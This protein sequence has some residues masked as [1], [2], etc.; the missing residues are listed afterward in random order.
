MKKLQ[1]IV[2]P[3]ITPLTRE[4]KLDVA[5][6]ERLMER[7]IAG[8]VHGFFILGT[9]GEGPALGAE[10]QRRMITES[11]RINAGRLPLL[12]GISA[13]SVEDSIALG[14]YS[15][16][17]GAYAVVA[18]PPSYFKP[19]E[20][21]LVDFYRMLAAKLPLPL[22]SYNMP[23]M[24]G[25]NL[26]PDLVVTL[27]E[28]P[29][30]IGH[31]DSSGNMGSFHYLL[32]RLGGRDDFAI[33]MGPEEL[34]GEAVFFGADGGVNGGANLNPALYVAMYEA[35]KRKDAGAMLSLQSAI[36]RQM[37]LYNCGHHQSSLIKGLK[38][39]L[40]LKGICADG[41]AAPFLPFNQPERDRVAEI[42]AE[43]DH[44]PN[45]AKM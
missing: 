9:T 44:F 16:A 19:G 27:A 43:L 26:S 15:H 1:G 25:I 33:F 5:G 22:F 2:P 23:G 18:T 6:L 20:A 40:S 10:L 31:K 37:R 13:T 3:V 24:T 42:L 32:Q 7:M 4:R 34:T 17:A 14:E 41:M 45:I 12:V 36:Y 11:A 35:A 38:C 39:A 29:N 30:I 28:I 8:G 21:E